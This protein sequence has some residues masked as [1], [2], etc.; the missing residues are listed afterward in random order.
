MQYARSLRLDVRF[1]NPALIPSVFQHPMSLVRRLRDPTGILL[2]GGLTCGKIPA[3]RRLSGGRAVESVP[4]LT[5]AL[6]AVC[7]NMKK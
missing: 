3:S 4:R 1:C 2:P 5:I 6:P 7:E